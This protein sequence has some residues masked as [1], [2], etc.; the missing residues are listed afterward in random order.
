MENGKWKMENGQEGRVRL[1]LPFSIFHLSSFIFHLPSSIFHLSCS[2]VSFLGTTSV[3]PW[4]QSLDQSF[5]M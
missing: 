3:A 4:R 2:I 5:E 1:A